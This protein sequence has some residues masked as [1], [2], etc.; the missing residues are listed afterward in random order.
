MKSKWSILALL[1]GAELL[2][3]SLW[4]TASAVSPEL[5]EAWDLGPS[6]A[7]WL[8]TV[9][10]LGFVAGTAFAA[11]LNLADLVPERPYFAASAALGAAAN[12]GLLAAP[13]Y[14]SALVLRF[15][16]GFFLAGV[17][18]P[19][20]KMV[21]TWFRSGRG[22]AIGTVVG[23][24]T[25]GKATPYLVNAFQG[26]SVPVVVS[27]ASAGALLAAV[28]VLVGYRT[29]PFAF[30]R[31]PFSW[32]LVGTVLEHRPTRL[33]IGGYLGHMF[34]LYAMWAAI[35]LFFHD[36]FLLRAA[37]ET[38]A[39]LAGAAGFSAIAA[40]AVG[41]VVAGVWADRWGRERIASGAMLL[42]GACALTMGWLLHAPTW[43]VLPLALVWG[44]SVVADSAQFSALVTEV[45]PPHAVGTALTL[46]TSLGFALTAFSIWITV[47][48][49]AR[50]GWGV[51]FALLAVGPALGIAAM[52]RLRRLRS[53]PALAPGTVPGG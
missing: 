32:R 46:Q 40:G 13:G 35:T 8:T 2:G 31:K 25:L 49:S 33:A 12:L 19:A 11:A 28:L 34:E 24:L 38:A 29:G 21:A 3:M 7:A 4:F 41:A 1:S 45:A 9:V 5:A 37:S 48:L 17:Y 27:T 30:Q 15:L 10:Q 36:Y 43:V 47:T 16:T 53:T 20:M 23:A 6:E 18:P 44:F 39:S 14:G 26:A 51:A 50:V 42:S 22:L 52:A